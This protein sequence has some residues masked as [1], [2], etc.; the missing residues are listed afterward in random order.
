MLVIVDS[1]FNPLLMQSLLIIRLEI[2]VD[3]SSF[4]GFMAVQNRLYG[5]LAQL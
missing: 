5:S 3:F 2:V 4:R 1:L